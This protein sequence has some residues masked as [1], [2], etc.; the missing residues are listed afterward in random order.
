MANYQHQRGIIKKRAV[1][2][3][4]HHPLYRQRIEKIKKEKGVISERSNIIKS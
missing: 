3:I 1:E 2:A 4:L